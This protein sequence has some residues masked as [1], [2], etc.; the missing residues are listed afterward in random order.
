MP[1][2]G[3]RRRFALDDAGQSFIEFALLLPI[4]MLIVV[5]LMEFSVFM[6]A[7]NAVEFAARDGSV[8]GAEGGNTP[9]TDCV[10]L[11]KVERDIVSPARNIR[12]QTVNIFWS[13][14]NGDQI[15]SSTNTYS[16]TGSLTC[17]YGGGATITVPY[18]LTTAN[19][20]EGVRCD[21]LA[22]CG[23]SHPGLDTIGVRVTYQHRWMTTIAQQS[24]GTITFSVGSATRMEPQQ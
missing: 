20:L 6:N 5:G 15:G 19:Y 11:D 9:G 1:L 12:I 17:S 3:R 23:V 13:D 2:H 18:T 10:V 24:G 21:V 16:R 14:K 8:L 4:V 22:G 7:R